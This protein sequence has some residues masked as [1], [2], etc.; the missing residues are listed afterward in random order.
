MRRIFRHEDNQTHR[1]AHKKDTDPS[2]RGFLKTAGAL[3]VIA[4]LTGANRAV[5]DNLHFDDDTAISSSLHNEAD[6]A[7]ERPS[8]Y[9]IEVDGIESKAETLSL[10]TGQHEVLCESAAGLVSTPLYELARGT[11]LATVDAVSE[12]IVWQSAG[13]QYSLCVRQNEHDTRRPV[14]QV[15]VITMTR[16]EHPDQM[17]NTGRGVI[18]TALEHNSV[19]SLYFAMDRPER[20]RLHT[21]SADAIAHTTDMIIKGL[22]HK[23]QSG[24]DIELRAAHCVNN[25]TPSQAAELHVQPNE[26]NGRYTITGVGHGLTSQDVFNRDSVRNI[27]DRLG[28]SYT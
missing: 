26:A 14:E 4:A 17:S 15:I 8:P 11:V 23:R 19:V 6:V 7:A 25:D 28:L 10:S 21:E 3:G 18:N 20:Y 2:R 16:G 22:T 12:A 24:H 1:P 27:V 5:R 13:D 9:P